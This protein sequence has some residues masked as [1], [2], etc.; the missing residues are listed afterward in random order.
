MCIIVIACLRTRAIPELLHQGCTS[1][2]LAVLSSNSTLAFPV[3]SNNGQHRLERTE[4]PRINTL[5]LEHTHLYASLVTYTL[6]CNC[7]I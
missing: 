2:T 6:I 5:Q 7:A 3:P 4:A 1:S